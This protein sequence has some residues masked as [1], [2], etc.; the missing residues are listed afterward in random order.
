MSFYGKLRLMLKSNSSK[1]YSY[2]RAIEDYFVPDKLYEGEIGIEVEVEG[3]NLPVRL[4]SYWS[5]HRDPSL[6]GDENLEYVLTRPV[7]RSSV[8]A[9]LNYLNKHLN[10]NPD[11][12]INQSKRCSTHIHINM[13]GHSILEAYVFICLYFLVED[14]LIQYAGKDRLGNM[15]SLTIKDAEYPIDFLYEAAKADNYNDLKKYEDYLR[16]GSINIAALA[17]YNSLEF[18]ALRGT[19]DPVIIT[20]WINILTHIKDRSLQYETPKDILIDMSIKGVKQFLQETLHESALDFA[21]KNYTHLQLEALVWE[22]LP[23]VQE[24]AYVINWVKQPLKK[25]VREFTQAVVEK[26]PADVALERDPN[27]LP[28][29]VWDINNI[30]VDIL[31]DDNEE[32]DEAEE[33]EED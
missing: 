17:K 6:R 3:E 12:R 14:I 20:T 22:A 24:I 5:V 21:L 13:Q 26:V 33:D 4:P 29:G 15:F 11:T 1:D 19:V 27:P 2:S 10:K 9:V 8:G 7:K 16:Y 23:L 31:D 32:D 25:D 28:A 30:L 18:R